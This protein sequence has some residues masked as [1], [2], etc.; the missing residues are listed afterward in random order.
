MFWSHSTGNQ[1]LLLALLPVFA[2]CADS[3]SAT[4]TVSVAANDKQNP[5]ANECAGTPADAVM[6][7]PAPLNRWGELACTPYGHVIAAHRGWIWTRPGAFSPVYVPAQ[8]V[9]NNPAEI[10]NRAY[11]SAINFIRVDTTAQIQVPYRAFRKI[12]PT[13]DLPPR[14]YRLDVTSNSGRSLR[15]YF[16]E[17]EAGPWGIW[18]HANGECDSSST[19]MILDMNKPR[20]TPQYPPR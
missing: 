18:C 6:T 4:R 15:L 1:L 12:F 20:Q 2:A 3:N 8:M 16:L 13:A 5:V 9:R 11:F 7:L 14:T 10:G 17:Y 19:F